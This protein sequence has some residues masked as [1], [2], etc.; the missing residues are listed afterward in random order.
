MNYTILYYSTLHYTIMLGSLIER[1][2]RWFGRHRVL[3]EVDEISGGPCFFLNGIRVGSKGFG[4]LVFRLLAR[5]PKGL[6]REALGLGLS[7]IVKP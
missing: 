7:G 3:E 4:I 6:Q 5:V 1:A 2:G